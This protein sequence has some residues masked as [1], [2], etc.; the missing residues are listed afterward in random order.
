MTS[1]KAAI[2]FGWDD[3]TYG[4]WKPRTDDTRKKR[5]ATL[6]LSPAAKLR[7]ATERLEAAIQ[8]HQAAQRKQALDALFAEVDDL[9][10][11]P[12]K[13]RELRRF[14]KRILGK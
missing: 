9:D 6:R 7:L 3:A 10:R 14:E 1:R 13:K 8:E 11:L 2:P 5:R 4:P 12:L